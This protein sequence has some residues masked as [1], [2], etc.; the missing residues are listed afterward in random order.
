MHIGSPRKVAIRCTLG[1]LSLGTAVSASGALASELTVPNEFTA[2]EPAV[3]A[4]VNDNFSETATAV[5]DNDARIAALEAQVAVLESAITALTSRTGAAESD[6]EAVEDRATLLE[7]RAGALEAR[8][9]IGVIGDYLPSISA[10]LPH[11]GDGQF[12]TRVVLRSIDV[13]A[14]HYAVWANATLLGMDGAV[15]ACELVA[16]RE[17]DGNE[18]TIASGG[19]FYQVFGTGVAG[20]FNV[21]VPLVGHLPA[22]FTPATIEFACRVASGD[23]DSRTATEAG[24]H[25]IS[26][27]SSSEQ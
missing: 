19:H 2:G 12:G 13:P 15:A 4:E 23:P 8:P 1:A 5:N 7:S 20:G 16:V 25:A 11:P 14:G 3:A 24:L 26:L 10:P 21:P 22:T 27:E 17:G 18:R 6:I 9:E